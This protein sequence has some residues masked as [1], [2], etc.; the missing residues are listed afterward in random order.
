MTGAIPA[1]LPNGAALLCHWGRALMDVI[2]HVGA[3]R[4]ATTSFQHYMRG[5]RDRLD[6]CGVAFWGP[7]RTRKTVFPGLFRTVA[8]DRR[9]RTARKAEGRVRMMT[10]RLQDAGYRHL[11]ISDENLIGTSS[12]NFRR[13]ALYPAIGERMA[14]VM[15][16]LDG[17]VTR[18]VITIRAQDQ[19]WASC[20][21]LIVARGHPVP[22]ARKC[23]AIAAH[24]RGWRDV[25]TDLACAAP[26]AE[27]L[28]LPFEEAAGHP[29]A[30]L[31][32]A[33]P[34]AAPGDR[35]ARW[36]NRSASLTDLRAVLR[37]EGADPALLPDGTGRWQ[38]FDAPQC[39][40]LSEQYADDLHWRAAGAEGLAHL[41][42]NPSRSRAAQDL[43][44]GQLTKGQDN[45]IGQGHLA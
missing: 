20:A 14:R 34:T 7:A 5:Q 15:A 12:Q 39:A 11:L 19:W 25:I 29:D 4:T 16:A 1:F 9:H 40:T 26:E 24:P 33:L 43:P 28:V 36:L 38:P 31:R 32:A 44:A 30:L 8:V 22:T 37:R 10:S 27:I 21:A 6:P 13:A 17:Q 42:R 3:H 23:A 41:T 35:A 45:A 2:L 18:I